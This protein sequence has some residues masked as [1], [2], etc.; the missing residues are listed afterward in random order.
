MG[1]V[2]G[3]EN[4][5]SRIKNKTEEISDNTIISKILCKPRSLS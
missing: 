5:C 2:Q 3:Q 1:D 4:A